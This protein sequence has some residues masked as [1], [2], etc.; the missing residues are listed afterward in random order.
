MTPAETVLCAALQGGLELVPRP[1]VALAKRACMS[2]S[3]VLAL[4]RRWVG[5]GLIR[6]FGVIVRHRELGYTANAMCVWDVP[7]D[8]VGDLG[9]AL[10][11]EPAVTLCYRRRRAL[12]LWRYNLFCMIHGRERGA[13][14][15]QVEEMSSRYR[16]GRFEHDVL[17]S[18]RRFKQNGARYLPERKQ[19]PRMAA[20]A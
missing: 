5:E 10:A 8:V 15:A 3:Q 14:E 16:L 6:R 7:D 12:P 13:V 20:A 18:T 2:E 1:F 19:M 11:T 4:I 17:F 9:C